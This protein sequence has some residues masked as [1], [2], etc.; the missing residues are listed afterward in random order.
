MR[1]NFGNNFANEPCIKRKFL[2]NVWDSFMRT[3]LLEFR[4]SFRSE[5]STSKWVWDLTSVIPCPI[6]FIMPNFQ[7]LPW[8][9]FCD[10]HFFSKVSSFFQTKTLLRDRFAHSSVFQIASIK[11][12]LFGEKLTPSSLWPKPGPHS[13]FRICQWPFRILHCRPKSCICQFLLCLPQRSLGPLLPRV[14]YF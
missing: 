1:L 9:L 8:S 13:H 4:Q 2:K 5:H 3:D 11:S 6:F 10:G 14:R 7:F 12:H